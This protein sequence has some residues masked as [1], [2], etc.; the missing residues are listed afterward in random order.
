MML[1][2]VGHSMLK[3]AS[4]AGHVEFG[5]TNPRDF[6]HD[7]HRTVDDKPIGGGPGMLM[8]AEPL[9]EAL[10]S[11]NLGPEDAV[12]FPEPTG[13]TFSQ[14][15]AKGLA[16]FARVVFVCGHYEGIDERILQLYATHRYSIGDYVLTGGELPAL[17]MADAVTRLVPGVLGCGDSL[18]ID[19]HEGGLLS[20]PQYARPQSFRGLEV[21]EILYSGDHPKIEKWKRRIA[22]ETTRQNRPDLFC[23]ARL[24][25]G[26]ADMLSF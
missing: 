17:V 6:T 22:L 15:A 11:L 12:V 16:G 5:A 26:D 8:L 25:K 7:S 3:R 24:E 21:P 9:A 10:D 23:R 14:T 20:A 18:A 13:T 19:S 1:S 4:E 2:A